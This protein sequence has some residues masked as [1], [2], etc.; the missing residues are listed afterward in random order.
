MVKGKDN[1]INTEL[2]QWRSGWPLV[3]WLD[4]K[5][6]ES[7]IKGEEPRN[8]SLKRRQTRNRRTATCCQQLLHLC[9]QPAD[10]APCTASII[11][12]DPPGKKRIGRQKGKP[13]KIECICPRRSLRRVIC[14]I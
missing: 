7:C 2:N 1:V 6:S 3:R 10:T 8:P 5:V 12:R 13:L 9:E 11:S 4:A 14:G